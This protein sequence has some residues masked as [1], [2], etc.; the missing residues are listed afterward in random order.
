MLTDKNWPVEKQATSSPTFGSTR[1]E[2]RTHEASVKP[3]SFEFEYDRPH[4]IRAGRNIR[5]RV[6]AASLSARRTDFT[7]TSFIDEA[8]AANWSRQ[9]CSQKRR[10]VCD[11]ST[12]EDTE[13]A[14]MSK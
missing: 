1:G 11:A 9:S 10:S 2:R 8:V 14:E 7:L 6:A 5:D 4:E 3:P 12:V 13:S